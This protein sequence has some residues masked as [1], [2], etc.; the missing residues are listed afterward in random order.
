MNVLVTGI[1][2]YIGSRLVPRLQREGHDVRGFSRHGGDAPPG[3]TIVTGDAVSGAGLDQA[4]DGVDVA[5]FLIHSMERS[6]D[7]SFDSRERAAAENFAREAASAGVR[8]I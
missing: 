4:L 7:G 6:D 8:R 5:Y 2:G 1:S 3:V